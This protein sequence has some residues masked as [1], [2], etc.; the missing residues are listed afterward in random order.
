MELHISLHRHL[1]SPVCFVIRCKPIFLT[2]FH[3]IRL[4]GTLNWWKLVNWTLNLVILQDL[5]ELISLIFC[6][7]VVLTILAGVICVT[8]FLNWLTHCKFEVNHFTR[9]IFRPMIILLVLD[10]IIQVEN[11][12]EI[13]EAVSLVCFLNLPV[14]DW[15]VQV[16]PSTSVVFLKVLLDVLL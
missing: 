11:M 7:N 1:I 4:F 12:S 3:I 10:E 16:I 8:W 6:H 15:Y 9:L 2:N 13:D 5:V 14:V